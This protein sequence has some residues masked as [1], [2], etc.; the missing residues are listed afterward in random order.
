[1]NPAKPKLL[2]QGCLFEEDFLRRTLGAIANTPDVALTELVANAWDAGSTEVQ[3]ELPEEVE[4]LLTI[5]DDGTGMTPSDFRKKWMTLGYDRVRNQGYWAEFPRER[6][7]WKRPAYGRNGVGRHGMLCFASEYTVETLRDGTLS[8][9]RVSTTAGSDP[10]ELVSEERR[11]RAGHGTTLTARVTRNLPSVDRIRAVLAARFLHDPQFTVR[12]NGKSVALAEHKGLVDQRTIRFNDGCR[13]EAFFIDSTRAA[14]TTQYQG[15]AFWVGHRLV[16][17]PSWTADGRVFLD[18]RTRIAK[19]YTVVVHSND[20]FDEVAPDWTGFKKS[21]KVEKLY[22]AVV[23]YVQDV[24]K[25][26]SE[27]RIQETTETVFREHIDDI[28]DLHPLAKLELQEFVNAVTEQQPTIQSETLS[29]AVQAVINLEKSR[30]GSAL[31]E[32][33][34]RLSDE[35]IEGLDRILKDWTV[36]DALTVLDELDRRL[37]TIEAVSKLS[38]DPKVDELHV[39]HP[40]VAESR[41]LF[42]HEFD[43]PEFVSNVTLSTAMRDVFK[44]RIS[45]TTFN[46][47]RKRVDILALADATISGT[48]TEQIE[49]ISGLAVL[50]QV[51]LIEL[52]KG[53]SEISREH[54]HQA[55]DY[56]EDFLRSGLLDGKPSFRV[57]VVGHRISDKLEPIRNVGER[58][59]IQVATYSQLV[60]SAQKR[61]FRLRER[62]TSRY[63]EVTGDALLTRILAEPQQLALA[64]R[65]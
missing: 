57:F 40:L 23:D 17:D 15:V 37:A 58:A 28:R 26:L 50:H 29:T 22:D 35:D 45:G 46:N 65:S 34:A 19:R 3:I 61:L 32:K 56:V 12:V 6:A 14:R 20:L 4:G 18:G 1:M 16:G 2:H 51:L 30:A 39:L 11:K 10:F 7:K 47:P 62:L 64:P 27:E 41:W 8:I 36:R 44:K 31:L 42:G 53:G 33:L 43:S 63:E 48:A 5:R 60:R 49:D 38:S 52:K 25:K 24:F 59:R 54:L 55:T 21:P 13:A 9:F